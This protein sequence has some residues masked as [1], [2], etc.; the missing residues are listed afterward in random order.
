M[1][2]PYS[3][4]PFSGFN[5]VNRQ[6]L[7]GATAD[8]I[9]DL[10]E[11]LCTAGGQMYIDG[12][13]KVRDADTFGL[14]LTP[15]LSELNDDLRIILAG[16]AV[17]AE[18]PTMLVING[19]TALDTDAAGV[20]LCGLTGGA[21]GSYSGTL[22]WDAA[23]PLGAVA[24]GGWFSGYVRGFTYA[25]SSH[26]TIWY[27]ERTLIICID[28]NAAS[29]IRW[30]VLG[31]PIDPLSQNAGDCE[32]NDHLYAMSVI[33]S[34]ATTGANGLYGALTVNSATA[35]RPFASGTADTNAH[36]V[37]RDP[38][39]G[40][41]QHFS[42]EANTGMNFKSAGNRYLPQPIFVFAGTGAVGPVLGVMDGI[43]HWLTSAANAR[44]GDSMPI[45]IPSGG[46]P[47][48]AGYFLSN[49][50]ATD[51]QSIFLQH[52]EDFQ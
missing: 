42:K 12:W 6:A 28:N 5:Q 19:V 52:I 43:F 7:V 14:A 49:G 4:I 51:L 24:A 27:N 10:L 13:R 16:R 46:T 25:T 17:D 11:T 35:N 40:K 3:F 31:A 32:A 26:I 45:K 9:L 22:N 1:S 38:A 20:L 41:W 47:Y 30:V 48:T 50:I 29:T 21:A 18:T 37:Y 36:S 33:G 39:T 15:P 34:V 23:D 2:N 44:L 8:A